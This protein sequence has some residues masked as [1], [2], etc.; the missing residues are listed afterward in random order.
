[1][2]Y[3]GRTLLQLLPPEIFSTN[4]VPHFHWEI[5]CVTI[6][7]Q[8]R[9]PWR[10]LM[11]DVSRHFFPKNE[12]KQLLDAMALY[13]INTFHWHLVDDNGWRIEIKKYP[14]L[15]SVGAWRERHRLQPRPQI[16]ATAYG[17]D[18]RYGGFYTQDDIRD[19]VA[20]AQKLHIT[21]IPEMEMPGHSVA[22]LA[23]YPEYSCTGQA[24]STDIGAGVHAGVYCPGKEATFEFLQNVLTEV[25]ALFPSQYIHLGGDEVP[26]DNWKACALCQARMKAEGLTN[27]EELQ[28]YFIRRM[29]KFVSGHGKTLIGWS[30]I[31]QGG[32]AQNAAVMD[33]IGGGA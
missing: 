26:K 31:L 15:T 10:G 20:Y 22:A 19:V 9:F 18:G 17:A 16:P 14:R 33:W 5:P 32:L 11:L 1:M 29:E 3:G 4:A 12:I 2:F 8:P 7:D 13:K 30:E 21:V 28:S 6:H 25:F 24:Q 23:A 27:E